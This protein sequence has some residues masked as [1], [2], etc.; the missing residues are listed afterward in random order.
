M[1]RDRQPESQSVRKLE[2]GNS[3]GAQ[4]ERGQKR[5]VK[6]ED[7]RKKGDLLERISRPEEPVSRAGRTENHSRDRRSKD[8][9]PAR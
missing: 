3:R 7:R 6:A 5:E 2:T 9:R 1:G 8:R 4:A